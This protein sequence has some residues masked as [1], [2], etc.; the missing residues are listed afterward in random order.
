MSLLPSHLMY[1]LVRVINSPA[2]SLLLSLFSVGAVCNNAQ[3]V[4]GQLL[5]QPT[6]GAILAAAIKVRNFEHM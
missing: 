5:G 6:D 1:S 2:D 3:I 4:G